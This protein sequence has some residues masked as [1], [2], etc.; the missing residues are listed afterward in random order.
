MGRLALAMGVV[1][2]NDLSPY[3]PWLYKKRVQSKNTFTYA[4]LQGRKCKPIII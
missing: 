1:E 2:V 4:F 3:F